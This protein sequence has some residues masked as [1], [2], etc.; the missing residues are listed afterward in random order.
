MMLEHLGLEAAG[1]SVERA[2]ASVLAEGAFRTPDLG[3]TSQTGEVTSAVIDRL[4]E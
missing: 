2:V 3:G 1:R 4:T